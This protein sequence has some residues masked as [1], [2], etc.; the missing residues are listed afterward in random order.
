MHEGQLVLQ[1]E[2]LRA[3]QFLAPH[4]LDRAGV[5]ARIARHHHRA[6]AGD[7]ADAYNNAATRNGFL[8][9]RLVEQIA[10]ERREFEKRR[11]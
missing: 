1:R 6:N 7:I 2:P 11:A 9:V 4:V 5:D 8:G 10:R 3:Q